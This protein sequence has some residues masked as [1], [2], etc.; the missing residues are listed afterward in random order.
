MKVDW[1]ALAMAAA[2]NGG[3]FIGS[4]QGL[5]QWEQFPD[6]AFFQ[7]LRLT[8]PPAPDSI[9]LEMTAIHAL[10]LPT[11]K[12]LCIDYLS[13][14]SIADQVV[15]RRN[16]PDVI[17]FDPLTRAVTL[18]WEANF[19]VPGQ[20][21]PNDHRIYCSGHTSLA[22]GRILFRGGG[23]EGPGEIETTVF[24]PFQTD[25]LL[26]FVPAPT[27]AWCLDSSA[28]P[29]EWPPQYSDPVTRWYPTCTTLGNGNVLITDGRR[30]VVGRPAVV[31]QPNVPV[32][33]EIDPAVAPASWEWQPLH[34]AFYCVPFAHPSYPETCDFSGPPGVLA[35]PFDVTYY[36]FM[37][38]LSNSGGRVFMAGSNYSTNL[39][40]G[41]TPPSNELA[42]MLNVAAEAWDQTYAPQMPI[43]GSSAV[44]LST[45]EA[46]NQRHETVYK[47][48][49]VVIP[50]FRPNECTAVRL[51]AQ[52]CKIAFTPTNGTP[53]WT[54]ISSLNRRR[55]NSTLLALPDGKLMAVNG[56]YADLNDTTTINVCDFDRGTL[57]PELYDPRNPG[58]GWADLP[59]AVKRR[60]R[61]ATALLLPDGRV[62]IA[63]G[64]GRDAVGTDYSERTY[65]IFRPIYCDNPNRPTIVSVGSKPLVYGSG[66][67]VVTPN[68]PDI[69]AV[70][71]IRLGHV[72]H[73]LDQNARLVELNST[74]KSATVRRVIAPSDGNVAPPG[75]YMLFV[76]TGPNGD[77]PSEGK[78]VRVG[79]LLS[80]PPAP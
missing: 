71:L 68:A 55:I 63:G 30:E 74:L 42:R 9:H 60:H 41:S 47:A 20:D 56:G 52:A 54:P 53:N 10:A 28:P 79:T 57:V 21:F 12:V 4:A 5:G 45:L 17:Q 29:G 25:P 7:P 73:S 18:I 66:I 35:Q 65:E 43:W 75:Y 67:D 78:I 36:P 48:G 11:G 23:G 39:A 51:E 34:S 49:G 69:T 46:G 72:T 50:D 24:D 19:T 33:L 26:R 31:G 62:F 40:D 2:F 22:D 58:A 14:Y 77:L 44:L 1:R 27:E 70:R 38:Q 59:A 8:N 16:R 3:T 13:S 61:H 37:F 80:A 76:C 6:G 64:Q 15:E 32:V